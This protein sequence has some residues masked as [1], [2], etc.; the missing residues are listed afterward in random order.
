MT[1]EIEKNIE[2]TGKVETP[3]KNPD[4]GKTLWLVLHYSSSFLVCNKSHN[5]EIVHSCFRR[6]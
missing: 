5:K 3:E 1:K 6:K 2:D 4:Y